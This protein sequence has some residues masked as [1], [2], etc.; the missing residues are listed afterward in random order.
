[1]NIRISQSRQ[2]TMQCFPSK[3]VQHLRE[4][5]YGSVEISH[6]KHAKSHSNPFKNIEKEPLKSYKGAYGYICAA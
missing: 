1:V 5:Q 2:K 4:L 6:V 3:N